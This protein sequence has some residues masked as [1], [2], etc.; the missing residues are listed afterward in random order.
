MGFKPDVQPLKHFE[1]DYGLK[2]LD[3]EAELSGEDE[4]AGGSEDDYGNSEETDASL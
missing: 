2:L 1:D 3:G 4:L